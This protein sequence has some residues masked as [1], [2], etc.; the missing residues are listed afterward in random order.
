MTL[1]LSQYLRPVLQN[2]ALDPRCARRA[3]VGSD[4]LRSGA[5]NRSQ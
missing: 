1:G 4:G 2:V 3:Y 5:V